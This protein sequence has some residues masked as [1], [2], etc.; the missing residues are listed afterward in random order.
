MYDRLVSLFGIDLNSG[1]TPY[2][3]EET[4]VPFPY[5]D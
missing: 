4:A 3:M 5:C 1:N 2:D